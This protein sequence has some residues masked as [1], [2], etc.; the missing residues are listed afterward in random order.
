MV[1]NA[2]GPDP[3]VPRSTVKKLDAP[4]GT[5]PVEVVCV[6]YDVATKNVDGQLSN[7][8]SQTQTVI[9]FMFCFGIVF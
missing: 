3:N 2:C 8:S 9:I 5:A 7:P 6:G 1:S 4:S